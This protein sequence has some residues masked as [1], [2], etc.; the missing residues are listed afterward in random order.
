[1]EN[2]DDSFFL[3]LPPPS[4]LPA[5]LFK[6]EDRVGS[7]LPSGEEGRR[8]L[9]WRLPKGTSATSAEEREAHT[10][11]KTLPRTRML[12]IAAGPAGGQ[13]TPFAKG[14]QA[15]ERVCVC[16]KKIKI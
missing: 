3:S 2:G 15:R 11:K 1:M 10:K 6:S 16:A 9:V 8:G 5:V 4:P 12:A 13:P 14:V 7:T